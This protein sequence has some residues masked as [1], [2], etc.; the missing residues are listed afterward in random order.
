MC[1]KFEADK[2][3]WQRTKD[4][5]I[6]RTERE[7]K[8]W[9]VAREIEMRKFKDMIEDMVIEIQGIRHEI[10]VMRKD[11]EKQDKRVEVVEW[12]I[13]DTEVGETRV[14]GVLAGK[15]GRAEG[16]SEE[17]SKIETDGQEGKTANESEK[18]AVKTYSQAVRSREAQRRIRENEEIVVVGDS[19]AR[20]VGGRLKVQHG[21]R[22]YAQG[23]ARIEEV[24]DHIDK[25]EF[26]G[27]ENL[28]VMAGGNNVEVHGTEVILKKFRELVQKIKEKRVK[29]ATVIGLFAR[30]HFDGYLTSKVL[31]INARLKVICEE[32]GLQY[33]EVDIYREG[34]WMIGPDGIHFTWD[35]EHLVAARIYRHIRSYLNERTGEDTA[36]V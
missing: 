22:V 18:K 32:A 20:Y 33:M 11:K 24:I 34:W 16:T 31:S 29:K 30:R 13:R 15:A 14:K 4:E 17:R 12:A 7:K 1:K 35:G 25:I 9:Q 3:E 23:G 19:M 8:D 28:V 27:G 26:S 2:V 5:E 36:V 21:G 6:E 10:D